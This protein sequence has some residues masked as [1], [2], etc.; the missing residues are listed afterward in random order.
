MYLSTY[1]LTNT[2]RAERAFPLKLL[3]GTAQ[4]EVHTVPEQPATQRGKEMHRDKRIMSHRQQDKNRTEQQTA[5]KR[6]KG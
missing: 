6:K 3:E 2:G 1:M 4:M 5:R